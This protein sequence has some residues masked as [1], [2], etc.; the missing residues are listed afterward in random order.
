MEEMK[1]LLVIDVQNDF[2]PGGS[3][4]VPEGDVIIPVLNRYIGFFASRGRPVFASRDWHPEKTGHFREHGGDWPRHCVAGTTGA[5]FHPGL[6]LPATAVIISKGMDPKRDSY[7]AFYAR[8]PDG[9]SLEG[10]LRRHG[11]TRIYVCGLATDYCVKWSVLDAVK[12]GFGATLLKDAT[13]GIDR[14]EGGVRK[15]VDE[16]LS[17]GARIADE[18]DIKPDR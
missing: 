16:M 9:T 3:L 11:V 6:D 12:L 4:P 15:A 1:A 8:G 5:D 17:A 7:S 14:E 10:L 18:K 2:C 13:K